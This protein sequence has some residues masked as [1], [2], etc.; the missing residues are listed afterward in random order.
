MPDDQRYV[1]RWLQVVCLLILLTGVVGGI[2]TDRVG[3]V[4]G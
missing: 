3:L 4:Y 2:T 1:I